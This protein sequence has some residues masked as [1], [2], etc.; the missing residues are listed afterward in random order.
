MSH[1]SFHLDA[2]AANP[3]FSHSLRE[4]TCGNS[5]NG[6]GSSLS[7]AAVIRL[8]SACPN[9]IHVTLESSIDLTDRAMLSLVNYC[10]QLQCLTMSGHDKG[11]GHLKGSVLDDLRQHPCLGKNL[12]QL[13]LADQGHGVG[14][15][16]AAKNL[17]AARKTCRIQTGD[18]GKWGFGRK[19]WVGGKREGNDVDL[20]GGGPWGH[21]GGFDD[22]WGFDGGG[23]F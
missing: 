11:K 10:P 12:K 5:N 6:Y 17:S 16:R 20:F 7:D 8:A 13:Y 3:D 22:F 23:Y 21:Q 1:N 2:I 4:L 9:L 15:E 14:F 19:D 18:S